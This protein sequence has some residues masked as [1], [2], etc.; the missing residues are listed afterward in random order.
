MISASMY[1]PILVE[2]DPHG[3]IIDAGK[4][5][6]G[7]CKDILP[8]FLKNVYPISSSSKESTKKQSPHLQW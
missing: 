2:Q 4:D 7:V 5:P 8:S 3:R 1:N 6:P